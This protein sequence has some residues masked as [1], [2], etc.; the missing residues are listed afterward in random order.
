MIEL[1][2]WKGPAVRVIR[3]TLAFS[4]RGGDDERVK[5]F[6]ASLVVLIAFVGACTNAAAPEAKR[7]ALPTPREGHELVGRDLSWLALGRSIGEQVK[8]TGHRA[9][10][11]RWW[12]DTCPFCEASL[13]AV[14]SLREKYAKDGLVALAVYHRK[15]E[16]RLTDDAIRAAAEKRGFHGALAV[17][18]DW[19]ALNTAWP[20]TIP[21][22][23]TSI[24]LLFDSNGVVRFAHPG[25]EYHPKRDGD[26]REHDLC[27]KDFDELDRAVRAVLSRI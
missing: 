12:T 27:V 14:E 18:E 21:R 11:V 19:K 25:P 17:D 22:A 1:E 2:R 3:R 5:I 23:A 20:D 6:G 24:T 8:M 7:I 16:Q 15:S 10:L 9:L 13:P 4:V 26:G